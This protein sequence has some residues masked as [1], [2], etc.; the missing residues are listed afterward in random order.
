MGMLQLSKDKEHIVLIGDHF[1]KCYEAIPLPDQT[2]S[3]TATALLDNWICTIGFP[4]SIHSY[5]GPN[6][7][8]KHFKSR[9]QALQNNKT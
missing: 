5:Q 4:H 2:A 7:E 8:S 6:F 1:S 9:N 3:T